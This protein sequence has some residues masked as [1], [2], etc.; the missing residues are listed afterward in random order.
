MKDTIEWLET[1]GKSARLRHAPA[2]ALA[3]T[4]ALADASDGLKAAVMTRDR[5]RL[6]TEFGDGSFWIEHNINITAHE[7]ELG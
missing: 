1:I 3:N 4:L 5:S 7:E 2:E 6:T